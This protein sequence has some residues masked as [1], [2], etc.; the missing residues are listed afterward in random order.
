MLSSNLLTKR[1][2]ACHRSSSVQPLVMYHAASNWYFTQV[3]AS[4][5]QDGTM[6]RCHPVASLSSSLLWWFIVSTKNNS[7]WR[8]NC[9]NPSAPS[10]QNWSGDSFV[11]HLSLPSSRRSTPRQRTRR[12]FSNLSKPKKRIFKNLPLKVG[13]LDLFRARRCL[14]RSGSRPCPQ[15]ALLPMQLAN[16]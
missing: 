5:S 16:R 3:F 2:T 9:T 10:P 12:G 11:T 8:S 14:L 6:H 4:P 1:L 7:C 13:T 15:P